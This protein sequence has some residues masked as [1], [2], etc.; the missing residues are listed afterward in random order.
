MNSA[1]TNLTSFII[2]ISFPCR[3]A[4]L[5]SSSL[6][7]CWPSPELLGLN[8]LIIHILPWLYYRWVN[9]SAVEY[10]MYF[11]IKDVN[12]EGLQSLWSNSLSFYLVIKHS[13]VGTRNYL[14]QEKNTVFS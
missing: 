14:L 13:P 1:K 6:S 7:S 2:M 10:R 12:K 8:G 4:E 9:I 3:T 5:R 11:T